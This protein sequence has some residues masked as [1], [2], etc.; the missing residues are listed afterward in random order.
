MISSAG[1]TPRGMFVPPEQVEVYLANGW[2]VVDDLSPQH[3]FMV[4]PKQIPK[5]GVPAHAP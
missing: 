2:K 3:C 4:P 1:T 5:P